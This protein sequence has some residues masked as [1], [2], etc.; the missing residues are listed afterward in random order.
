L[1]LVAS[2]LST[3]EAV[4]YHLMQRVASFPNKRPPTILN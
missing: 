3:G 2:F 1:G 4:A